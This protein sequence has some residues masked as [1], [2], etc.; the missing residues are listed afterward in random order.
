MWKNRVYSFYFACSD[1][2]KLFIVKH[3]VEEENTWSTIYDVFKNYI[4]WSIT[5]RRVGCGG[6]LNFLL[7][8]KLRKIRRV[9]KTLVHLVICQTAEW[10]SIFMSYVDEIL[11]KKLVLR[12]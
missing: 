2:K 8:D 10:I 6:K 9:L 5:V 12:F 7:K 4:S 1:A 3:L 11:E